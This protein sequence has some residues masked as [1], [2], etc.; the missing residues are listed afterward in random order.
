MNTETL[1]RHVYVKREA[2][3]TQT[4]YTARYMSIEHTSIIRGIAERNNLDFEVAAG[5]ALAMFAGMEDLMMAH[6][7]F[8]VPNFS[9]TVKASGKAASKRIDGWRNRLAPRTAT[10]SELHA[11]V[12]KNLTTQYG[13]DNSNTSRLHERRSG[14][15]FYSE[16]ERIAFIKSER[17]R[18]T[19]EY[20][21]SDAHKNHCARKRQARIDKKA[22]EKLRRKRANKKKWEQWAIQQNREHFGY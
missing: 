14:K 2:N 9:V 7:D 13:K 19:M 18:K 16:E 11:S 21:N 22:E 12:K 1:H 15:V 20:I 5:Y 6:I 8:E 4:A 10:I 17:K 3:E